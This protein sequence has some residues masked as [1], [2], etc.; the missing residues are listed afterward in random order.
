MKFVLRKNSPGAQCWYIQSGWTIIKGNAERFASAN[1]AYRM[2]QGLGV[3]AVV[4]MVEE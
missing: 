4:D 1:D 3:D 2:M